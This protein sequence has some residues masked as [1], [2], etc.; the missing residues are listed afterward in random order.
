MNKDDS[1]EKHQQTLRWGAT[2]KP[3]ANSRYAEEHIQTGKSHK[4]DEIKAE[5]TRKRPKG[6]NEENDQGECMQPWPQD[7]RPC[8]AATY[9]ESAPGQPRTTPF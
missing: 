5:D 2:T 6:H 8:K 1:I 9:F 7:K 4:E 3:T